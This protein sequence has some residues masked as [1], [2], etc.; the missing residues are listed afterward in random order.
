MLLFWIN[1]SKI[2]FYIGVVLLFI[3]AVLLNRFVGDQK[4]SKEN[5]ALPGLMYILWMAIISKG[6]ILSPIVLANTFLIAGIYFLFDTT[7]L[8]SYVHLVFNCGFYL[9][10]AGLTYTP[11]VILIPLGIISFYHIKPLKFIEIIQFLGGTISALIIAILYVYGQ[12]GK[13][14]LAVQF[15]SPSMHSWNIYNDGKWM[16]AV[17][18][19]HLL[20]FIFLSIFMYQFVMEKKNIIARKKN[21]VIYWMYGAFSISILVFGFSFTKL[22]CFAIPAGIFGGILIADLKS[23]L[24]G[25]IAHLW[26]LIILFAHIFLLI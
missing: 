26:L 13:W 8:K 25:E 21:D 12:T 2:S 24:A 16:P 4:M 14:I 9:G 23:R 19:L 11:Y 1:S 6:T 15:S 3:Q 22:A 17:V 10:L 7:R 18:L 20:L 5:T